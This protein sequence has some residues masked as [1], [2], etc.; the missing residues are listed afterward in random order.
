MVESTVTPNNDA[1][2]A[3]ASENRKTVKVLGLTKSQWFTAVMIVVLTLSA[4]TISKGITWTFV[5]RLAFVL[6]LWIAAGQLA[7][8]KIESIAGWENVPK[9]FKA[10]SVALLFF[11]FILSGFGTWTGWVLNEADDCFESFVS[12]DYSDCGAEVRPG[13]TDVTAYRYAGNADGTEHQLTDTKWLIFHW[14]DGQSCLFIDTERPIL[15]RSVDARDQYWIL[16]TDGMQTISAYTIPLG[17][18]M[19]GQTCGK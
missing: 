10:T 3:T 15:E 5:A 9:T 14:P 4:L 11:T 6:G 13:T 8:F 7:K 18:T 12:G 1:A 16:S 2:Q 19:R 17:E